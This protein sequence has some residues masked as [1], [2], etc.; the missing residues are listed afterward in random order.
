MKKTTQI[1]GAEA[2]YVGMFGE[3]KMQD[4][5]FTDEQM[6]CIRDFLNET[7]TENEAEVVKLRFGLIDGNAYSLD[8]IAERKGTNAERIRQIEFKAMRKLRHPSRLELAPKLLKDEEHAKEVRELEIRLDEL[9][10]DPIFQREY[11][12][13]NRLMELAK[14]PYESAAKAKRLSDGDYGRYAIKKLG[15]SIKTH[16]TLS[17]A[18]IRTIEDVLRYPKKDWGNVRNL[19]QKG[20]EELETRMRTL[21]YTEFSV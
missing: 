1:A 3:S 20:L 21:G 19:G 16:N 5:H 4:I 13:K 11:E 6:R 17:R 12:L 14:A 7:L 9:Y 8:E 15:L 18:G 10:K 2:L